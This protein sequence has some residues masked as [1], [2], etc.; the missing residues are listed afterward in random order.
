MKQEIIY[1]GEDPRRLSSFEIEVDKKHKKF[2]FKDFKKLTEADFN[3]LNLESKFSK[4]PFTKSAE[5]TYQ[6]VAKLPIYFHQ[7]GD[8]IILISH[9]EEQQGLY[10]IML[11]GVVKKNSNVNIYHNIN[12][13]DDVK[14]MGVSF[15][16]MKDFHNP[17]T[18]AIYSD[19]NYARNH[20]SFVPD[21][22]RMD[23]FEV[24]KDAKQTDFISAGYLRSNG[25]FIRKSVFNLLKEFNIPDAKFIPCTAYQNNKAEEIYFLNILE[26]TRVELQNS[27]FHISGGIHSSIDEKIIFNNL[28]ELRQKKKE[29]VKTPER[30]SLIPFDMKINAGTDFLKIPGTI[31]FFISEN[32]LTKLEK[33]NISGYEI[34]KISYNVS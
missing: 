8:H 27:T 33:E 17:P 28:K 1:K 23:L 6:G 11:Y 3:R 5:N 13:L 22:V 25:F 10:S 24:K 16:Q 4:I 34:S 12:Y 7:D 32:L 9:G 26:S 14:I 19:R 21:E 29:L 30:P 31:D 18:K 15:P 2:N 20:V